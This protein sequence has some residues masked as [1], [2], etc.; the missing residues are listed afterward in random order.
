M[1]LISEQFHT[2]LLGR[3]QKR[4]LPSPSPGAFRALHSI[5]KPSKGAFKYCIIFC[6]HQKS[7][8]KA[9]QPSWA[10]RMLSEGAR[11]CCMSSACLILGRTLEG[12]QQQGHSKCCPLYSGTQD[13]VGPWT[14]PPLAKHTSVSEEK[15]FAWGCQPWHEAAELDQRTIMPSILFPT[16]TKHTLWG[17]PPAG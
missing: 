10:F 17:S 5:P 12:Q 4:R 16:M 1:D 9:K 11:G 13:Y 7:G 3:P 2:L 14:P 15:C 8:S 6:F